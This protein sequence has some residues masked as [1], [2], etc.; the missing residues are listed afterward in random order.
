MFKDSE[1]VHVSETHLPS[2][3]IMER[4]RKIYYHEISVIF[5]TMICCCFKFRFTLYVNAVK[6]NNKTLPNFI[7]QKHA[8]TVDNN[9]L[10]LKKL[11]H[12][13][14]RNIHDKWILN[15]AQKCIN[16]YSK[17]NYNEH[18]S[19]RQYIVI[20]RNLPSIQLTLYEVDQMSEQ[21]Y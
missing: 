21:D 6:R 13:T 8:L 11:R 15:F 19:S 18:L 7:N 1:N 14:T 9:N 3:E 4:I 10:I 2:W 20:D 16:Q 17:T 12:R 5:S